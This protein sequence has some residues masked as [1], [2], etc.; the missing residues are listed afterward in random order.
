LIAANHRLLKVDRLENQ[1]ISEKILEQL[2]AQLAS[3]PAEACVFSDFR[4]GIFAAQTIPHLIAAIPPGVFRA[5]DSQ[6]ASRWGNILDFVDFD[7]ITPNEREAR[8]ALGDQ[9]SVIR[10][11]AMELYK[12][13]RCKTLLLLIGDRGMITY[14]APSPDVRSFFTVDSFA[15][16]VVDPVG[17]GDALLAYATLTLVATQSCVIASIVGSM[18]AAVACEQDGNVPVTPADVLG[19]LQAV[20]QHAHFAYVDSLP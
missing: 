5:A 3:S 7:L 6:V 14:R 19:K 16:N 13:A 10:P 4:H 1:P 12:K 20:E 15:R 18:A 17:A 11:L 8:F 2:K 9:D